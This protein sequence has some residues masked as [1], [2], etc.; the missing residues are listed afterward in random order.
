MKQE[1]ERLSRSGL[2][3]LG[4]IAQHEFQIAGRVNVE[5]AEV[6]LDS[7]HIKHRAP[8]SRFHPLIGQ[9]YIIKVKG[10]GSERVIAR[11]DAGE[12]LNNNFFAIVNNDR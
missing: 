12:V 2:S 5:G 6:I 11:V 4:N 1:P 8:E 9:Q 10:A 7:I 3:L